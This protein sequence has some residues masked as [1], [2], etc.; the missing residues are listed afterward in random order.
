MFLL[1]YSSL[2]ICQKFFVVV[3][4]MS[5]PHRKYYLPLISSYFRC[6]TK[7]FYCVGVEATGSR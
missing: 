4:L 3:I 2:E 1:G 6:K 7:G 5:V